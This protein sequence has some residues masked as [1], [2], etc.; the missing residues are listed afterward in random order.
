MCKILCILNEK[1]KNLSHKVIQMHI[2]LYTTTHKLPF[3][4]KYAPDQHAIQNIIVIGRLRW[5]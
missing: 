4:F 5:L 1:H 3:F 2:L